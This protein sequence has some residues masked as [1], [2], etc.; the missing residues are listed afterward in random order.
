ME[1]NQLINY[2]SSYGMIFVFIIVFLEYLNLPGLPA[3]IILPLIG[4]LSSKGEGNLALV[5]IISVIA[6][7]IGSWGLYCVGWFGGDFILNK[8]TNKFPK[9][10]TYIDKSI[11]V[12]KEKGNIG[13]FISMLIPM[14]RTMISVPA[15]VLKL[16]FIQYSIYSTLGIIL[17]NSSLILSGY[18]FGDAVF[19]ILA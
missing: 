13:V 14:L 6:G 12:L 5:L 7:A 4:V 2:F 8:Y 16:N 1:I 11:N 3:G 10:K 15:G 19:K 18:F 17:W 9:H